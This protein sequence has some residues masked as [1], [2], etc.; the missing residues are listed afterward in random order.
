MLRAGYV[1]ASMHALGCVFMG[2]DLSC[3][4]TASLAAKAG[5]VPSFGHEPRAEVPALP[6]EGVRGVF[7]A[8]PDVIWDCFAALTNP[9]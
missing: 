4:R 3:G 6:S 7:D 2:P 1:P 5:G 8:L 9:V